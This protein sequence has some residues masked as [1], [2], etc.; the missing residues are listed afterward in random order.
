MTPPPVVDVAWLNQNKDKVK[1][2][3]VSSGVPPKPDWKQFREQNYGKFEEL[4]Q[5]EAKN[6]PNEFIPNSTYFD[7]SVAYYPGE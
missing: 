5:K 3:A 4:I 7:L 1:I 6:L 2:V